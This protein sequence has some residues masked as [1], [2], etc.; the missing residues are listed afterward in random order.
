MRHKMLRIVSSVCLVLYLNL[1]V[2]YAAWSDYTPP[3]ESVDSVR[4]VQNM[5]QTISIDT[6]QKKILIAECDF[7]DGIHESDTLKFKMTTSVDC[8]SFEDGAIK[9]IKSSENKITPT[10]IKFSYDGDLVSGEYYAFSCN[11]KCEG[12][13]NETYGP[14]N[15]LEAYGLKNGVGDTWLSHSFEF[16][17]H[18]YESGNTD[19]YNV[20][21]MLQIPED[22]EYLDLSAYVNEGTEGTIY[23]DDF[24]LYKIAVDPMESVLVSPSYKGLIYTEGYADINLDVVIEENSFYSLSDME[25]EVKLIDE[26]DNILRFSNAKVLSKKMNF[27]F[28]SHGI[29]IGTY[30]LQA[31]LKNTSTGEVVSFKEHTI[32]RT[33][34]HPDTYLNENGNLVRNGETKFF[35][36]IMSYNPRTEGSTY[37]EVAADAAEAGLDSISQ[38][39]MWW[40][41]DKND[42]SAALEYMRENELQTHLCLAGY[43]WGNYGEKSNMFES[44]VE[45]QEDILPFLTKI[46]NDYKNDAVLDGYYLFDEP[47]PVYDG[48]EIRWNNEILAEADIN[49][50]TY[51]IADKELGHYGIY[52]KMSDVLGVDPYPVYGRESDDIAKVGRMVK[53]AKLNFP[54]RPVYLVLQCFNWGVEENNDTVRGPNYAELRNM[55]WQGICEG[56]V[57]LDAFSY[58]S[59]T[60]DTKKNFDEWWDDFTLVY[61]EVEQYGDVIISEEPSPIYS[62]SGGGEWLNILVK[63]FNGQTYVFAVN[64]TKIA[65]TAAVNIVGADNIDL[66]FEPLEVKILTV[67][68][69]N[70]LSPEAELLSFEVSA[71]DE[72]FPVGYGRNNNVMFIP[73]DVDNV[74]Y[75]A[76]ISNGAKLFVNGFERNTVGSIDLDITD[77]IVVRVVAEN[78]YTSS[79][80]IYKITNDVKPQAHIYQPQKYVVVSGN[81]GCSNANADALVMLVKKDADINNIKADDIGYIKQGKVKADGTYTFEFSFSDF[82]YD[83]NGNVDNYKLLL[84]VNGVR[85]TSTVSEAKTMSN[86]VTFDLDISEVGKAVVNMT[87]PY[88]LNDLK[89]TMYIAFYNENK[90]LDIKGFDKFISDSN[91]ISYSLSDIPAGATHVR[92]FLW[93]SHSSL[94][95]LASSKEKVLTSKPD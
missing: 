27:V 94:I 23:F 50:P 13:A 92:G 22:T 62:V 32:R 33:D 15:L 53:E 87:N 1:N 56:A 31:V 46:A 9:I 95:P 51:G 29:P 7:D 28:S 83:E 49:H 14:T 52:T 4:A 35:K 47:N 19:W 78:G 17:G 10:Q 74:N 21:Q 3:H 42:I 6:I 84:N 43:W 26:E 91:K 77:E 82:K 79:E 80:H 90:L 58:T 70:Y 25:L 55:A 37:M 64:N 81:A 20:C 85:M 73:G 69:N 68:Q 75:A 54:N 40:L 2:C 66:N 93:D 34:E 86:L 89:Y 63:R 18:R 76:K 48:E 41:N 39:G 60:L 36:K 44:F 65:Q 12:V 45:K 38:Y 71:G 72:S 11:I 88:S 8:V 61:D 30:Y 16:D 57:G 67:S 24:K 5:P 59:M